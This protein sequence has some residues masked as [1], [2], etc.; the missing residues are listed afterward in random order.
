MK[1]ATVILCLLVAA[2]NARSDVAETVPL[3]GCKNYPCSGKYEECDVIGG[4]PLCV[5]RCPTCKV[6]G[7]GSPV[8]GTDGKTYNSLCR[9]QQAECMDNFVIEPMCT[10]KCPCDPKD[11]ETMDPSTV[12]KLQKLRLQV[13]LDRR[14]KAEMEKETEIEKLKKSERLSSEDALATAEGI[15]KVYSEKMRKWMKLKMKN[16]MEMYKR[17]TEISVQ[18]T[19]RRVGQGV[20]LQSDLSELPGRLIDWFHVLKSNEQGD[21]G[22]SSIKEMSFLDAKLKAMYVTLAC[23][24]DPNRPD[25][26]VFCLQPVQWM[27]DH[28]DVNKN[29]ILESTELSDLESVNSE[30]CMKKFFLG[31]DRNRNG[32]VEKTEFCRCLC[33]E[34]P[35]TKAIENIPTLLIAGVPRPVPGLFIPKCNE[36]GFYVSKQCTDKECFC[37]DRNG[38]EVH[39]T[40]VAGKEMECGDNTKRKTEE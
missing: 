28:L 26:E 7:N 33:V 14:F 20:C 30:H 36:D 34:P 16:K 6:T 2:T 31:C 10:G 37:V 22:K 8:C 13:R 1:R 17:K 24:K 9:L 18:E 27:F 39:G 23:K 40:R 38:L 4:T 19:K 29:G 5:K 25:A 35:C 11:V 12:H 3:D 21:K 32:T 15:E